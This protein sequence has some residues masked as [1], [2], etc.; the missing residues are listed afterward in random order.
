MGKYTHFKNLSAIKSFAIG[1]KGYEKEV[2]N[3]DGKVTADVEGNVEGYAIKSTTL[4]A[5]ADG[6]GTGVVGSDVTF[7]TVTSANANHIVTLPAPVVGRKITLVNGATGY[8]IRSSAPA[9][10]GINGGVGANAE[11]AVGANVVVKLEC[12]SLTNWI[13]ATVSS[14]GVVGVLEVAAP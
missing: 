11:S 2:I 13:G 1:K 14:A 3:E 7:A 4:T 6:T 10:I 8:E 5:T 9:T 12:V